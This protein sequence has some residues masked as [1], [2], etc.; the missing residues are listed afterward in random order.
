MACCPGGCGGGCRVQVER[1]SNTK[2]EAQRR[3]VRTA[4][5]WA[6]LTEGPDNKLIAGV[7]GEGSGVHG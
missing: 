3:N 4:S 7:F 6:Q 2:M 5:H 1:V